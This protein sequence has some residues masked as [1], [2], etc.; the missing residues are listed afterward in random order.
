MVQ[1][2]PD[3]NAGAALVI[4]TEFIRRAGRQEG[5]TGV[6][7]GRRKT[8]AGQDGMYAMAHASSMC[9]RVWSA[10][11]GM[12]TKAVEGGSAASATEARPRT[13]LFD[14]ATVRARKRSAGSRTAAG[15][16]EVFPCCIGFVVDGALVAAAGQESSRRRRRRRRHRRAQDSARVQPQSAPEDKA[17]GAPRQAHAGNTVAPEARARV[18]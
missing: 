12:V 10:H 7:R 17:G 6:R 15:H 16:G 4:R 9:A 3:R 18:A 5:R 8:P 2:R 1:L 13:P 14:P 11:A